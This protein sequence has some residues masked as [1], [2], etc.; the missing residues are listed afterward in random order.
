MDGIIDLYH[1]ADFCEAIHK[2]ACGFFGMAAQGNLDPV[3]LTET[4]IN[5]RLEPDFTLQ[6]QRWSFA[7]EEQF[8][9]VL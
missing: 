3:E 6:I 9:Y 8:N 4:F 5:L 2:G 7:L 1:V